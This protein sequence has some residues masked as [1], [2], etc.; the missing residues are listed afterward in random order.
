MPDDDSAFL[1]MEK[2]IFGHYAAATAYD[3]EIFR[4]SE[5]RQAEGKRL[6]E[7]SL[8]AE[9]RGEVCLSSEERWKRVFNMPECIENDRLNNLQEA[10][11]NEMEYLVEHM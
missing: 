3:D 4:L 10:H 6:C 11:Y 7:E 1:A 5:I 2:Q 9:Q 8:T